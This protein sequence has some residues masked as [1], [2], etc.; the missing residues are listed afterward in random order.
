[1]GLNNILVHVQ[2][3]QSPCI[4]R[5]GYSP[6]FS[7]LNSTFSGE[8]VLRVH[9][10]LSSSFSITLKLSVQE[11]NFAVMFRIVPLLFNIT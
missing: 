7:V 8:Q 1:M 4:Y 3:R 6:L 2:R 11:K 9:A 5:G 10:K